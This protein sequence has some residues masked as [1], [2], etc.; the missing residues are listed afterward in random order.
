[1][2]Y[3]HAPNA[4]V[5]ALNAYIRN[6]GT[7][8]AVGPCFTQDEHGH[9]RKQALVASGRGR[10]VTY[11]D[12]LT[13]H[14]YREILDRLLDQT[15]AARPAQIEGDHG[16]P[17]WGVNVRAVETDGRL[18]VNLLNL[19]R[20]PRRVQLVTKPAAKHALNLMDGKQIE[21]PFTLSPLEPV[22]LALGPR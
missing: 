21:F 10:L 1:M 5:K 3:S 8:M 11:P 18:L 13:A 7:V 20:E 14:A 17:V 2:E 19:S 12:S 15:G 6:G 16:E 4:G 9:V 22:V